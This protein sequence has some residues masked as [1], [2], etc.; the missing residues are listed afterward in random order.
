MTTLLALAFFLAAP[1][2]PTCHRPMPGK[3]PA[4]A[5]QPAVL[6]DGPQAFLASLNAWRAT[7]GRPPVAWDATLAWYASTNSAVHAP[8]SSGGAFQC[9]APTTG[10]LHALSMW[11]R[12]GPHAAILLGARSAVGA[13]TCPTGLT[14]NAR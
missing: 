14:C 4:A 11:Q 12:S 13:W 6:A 7:Q 9:W 10:Y 3:A 5:V 1:D 8:G 2:C